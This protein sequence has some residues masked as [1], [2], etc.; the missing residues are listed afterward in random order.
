M[1]KQTTL[2]AHPS[3]SDET[4]APGDLSPGAVEELHRHRGIFLVLGTGLMLLGAVAILATGLSTLASVVFLGWLLLVGGTGLAIHAFWTTRWSGFFLQLIA[5]LLYCVAGLFA[6]MHPRVGA[7]ALTLVIAI[8]LIGHGA[9]RIFTAMS[10]R[11]GG[12]GT[13]LVT[14]IIAIVLGLMILGEWP[15]SGLWV[16]GLFVGTDMFFYGGWLV[17]LARYRR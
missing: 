8:S 12:R 10:T 5:G 2:R 15:F 4:T 3:R 1:K 9:L 6:A 13:L 7:V 14:G 17:S 16:I 11:V